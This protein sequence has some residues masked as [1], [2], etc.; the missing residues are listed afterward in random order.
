ME[1]ELR[2]RV[3]RAAESLMGNEALMSDLET[4]AAQSLLSW[5]LARAENAAYETE[6][7]EDDAAEEALYPRLRAIRM[8][9]RLV[10]RLV[11]GGTLLEVAAKNEIFDRILEQAAVLYGPYFTPPDDETR[12][13]LLAN[14]SVPPHK[15]IESLRALFEP[16]TDSDPQPDSLGNEG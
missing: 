9:M 14:I 1:S 13:N 16:G 2:K 4:E 3:R 7:V 6:S 12:Q 5:G 8:L 10:T 15:F 11:N